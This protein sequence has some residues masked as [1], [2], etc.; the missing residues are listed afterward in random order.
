ML[1]RTQD[2]T[3]QLRWSPLPESLRYSSII[4]SLLLL[5]SIISRSLLLLYVS[6]LLYQLSSD[7]CSYLGAASADAAADTGRRGAG[8]PGLPS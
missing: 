7:T 4:R 8:G 6:F 3:E 1:L 2:A 5:Y